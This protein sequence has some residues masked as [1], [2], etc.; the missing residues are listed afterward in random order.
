MEGDL[1]LS[2]YPSF[3]SHR[4]KWKK[5]F[6]ASC[7]N[8]NIFQNINLT[9]SDYYTNIAVKVVVPHFNSSQDADLEVQENDEG[10]DV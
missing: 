3:C 1:R 2:F 8:V 5:R 7:W 4:K 6:P 10:A 9:S